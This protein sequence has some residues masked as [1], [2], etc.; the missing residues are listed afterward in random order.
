MLDGLT[1]PPLPDPLARL[2]L[3]APLLLPVSSRLSCSLVQLGLV[4]ME[5]PT[6]RSWALRKEAVSI[7]RSE[8]AV[9]PATTSPASS[10]AATTLSTA[11]QSSAALTAAPV[12]VNTPEQAKRKK[13]AIQMAAI[14]KTRPPRDR[15]NRT[16]PAQD[17]KRA[18]IRALRSTIRCT[19]VLP[20]DLDRIRE[21]LGEKCS[22]AMMKR[23]FEEIKELP[24]GIMD[25]EKVLR[26]QWE[27]GVQEAFARWEAYK[28]D[29]LPRDLDHIREQ[30]EQ[31]GWA[32]PRLGKFTSNPSFGEST[33][34]SA[35][36]KRRFEEIKEL[37]SGTMDRSELLRSKW[38]AGMQEAFARWEAYKVET[39]RSH[40]PAACNTPTSA[41]DAGGAAIP[42]GNDAALALI[43]WSDESLGDSDGPG[44]TYRRTT[45]V[46]VV[47][48]GSGWAL[49]Y[50]GLQATEGSASCSS[51]PVRPVDHGDALALDAAH[52][53]SRRLLGVDPLDLQTAYVPRTAHLASA[54]PLFV[55]C[56]R[57]DGELQPSSLADWRWMSIPVAASGLDP[58][59]APLLLALQPRTAPA[60]PAIDPPARSS[61]SLGMPTQPR[62]APAA[63]AIDPPARSSKSL[64]MP[65]IKLDETDTVR[66][67]FAVG[68]R[69]EC[70]CG[71][72]QIGTVIKLFYTQQSFPAGVCAP[73]QVKLDSGRK[74]F[75]KHDVDSMIRPTRAQ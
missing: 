56:S 30:L 16:R 71:Q 49:P 27:A 26:S 43:R 2:S 12:E 63:P 59:T 38:R 9:L 42:S 36:M 18:E 1:P 39:E 60:A 55:V 58:Y 75:A 62:T 33:K 50:C 37:P 24:S 61:K 21:Q 28:V 15:S 72:W 20:H 73:Y 57:W 32:T 67:R 65:T 25:S 10:I 52:G 31:L 34:H 66:L 35:M 45:E 29:V 41:A 69:V 54:A 70:N 23:R 51:S 46:L 8:T 3:S 14:E 22:E 48:T 40:A 53:L 64:G 19:S 74:V 5:G 68:D 17:R 47:E 11:S 13:R 7:T 4:L 44:G 6:D